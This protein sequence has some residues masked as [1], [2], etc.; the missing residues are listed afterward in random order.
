MSGKLAALA[1]G[2]CIASG[3]RADAPERELGPKDFAYGRQVELLETSQPMAAV[4]VPVELYRD[5]RSEGLSD[6]WVFNAEGKP[7]PHALRRASGAA[8]S[9]PAHDSG[10]SVP[11]FPVSV[12]HAAAPLELSVTISRAA[13]GQVLALQSQSKSGQG[14]A[15]AQAIGAYLLD[16]RA[17]PN[18]ERGLHAARF[19]WLDPPDNLILPL[20]IE[21]SADLISWQPLAVEGGLLHLSHAGQRIDRDRVQ[22]SARPASFLRVRPLDRA[23]FPAQLREVRV[24]AAPDKPA[25]QRERVAVVAGPSSDPAQGVYR[26]DLG[27][28]V[29]VDELEIELPED[30]SV[31]AGELWSAPRAEGPYGRLA[32]AR[33]YR[34]LSSGKPLIGPRLTVFRQRARSYELR[35][36]RTRVGIGAGMPSLVTYHTPEQLVFLLR[37][38]PPFSV[39]YGR[40][41]VRR[42]RFEPEELL[43]LLP[44]RPDGSAATPALAQLG[45]R[46]ELGGPALLVPPPPEPPYKTYALWA[47]LIAGVGLLGYLAYRLARED[48]QPSQK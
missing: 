41:N 11:F 21:T 24:E 40:H 39:A 34:V 28:E 10:V 31:I 46:R 44:A 25:Q 27:G 35:V 2:L 18:A 13:D 3:A 33:F 12:Q 17:V 9:G 4:D 26:F 7:V 22:W 15:A 42:Q 38:S 6:V 43:G 16:V 8:A 19:A 14:P 5:S 1:L 32:Q 23:S 37:G 36:D 48:A 45:P 47:V 20:Q 29:P 30:N